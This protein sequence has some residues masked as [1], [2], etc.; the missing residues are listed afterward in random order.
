MAK[1]QQKNKS[2]AV[3]VF[4]EPSLKEY[5][6]TAVPF[7]YKTKVFV[8]FGLPTI[9]FRHHDTRTLLDIAEGLQLAINYAGAQGRNI[10]VG[11]GKPEQ[12]VVSTP[13]CIKMPI[14]PNFPSPFI[15]ARLEDDGFVRWTVLGFHFNDDIA[16]AKK[17]IACIEAIAGFG[18]QV[19]EYED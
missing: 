19:L 10:R 8:N 3:I 18:K 17:Y 4:N 7:R 13:T 1:Y 16:S 5:S 11:G 2:R 6:I 14:F 15:E 9:T 12:L